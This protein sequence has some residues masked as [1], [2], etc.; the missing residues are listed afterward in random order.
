VAGQPATM[1][2]TR[3]ADALRQLSVSPADPD[4]RRLVEEARFSFE[5]DHGRVSLTGADLRANLRQLHES[6]IPAHLLDYDGPVVPDRVGVNPRFTYMLVFILVM[7]VL[8]FGCNNA[9][10]EIVKEEAIFARERA[11]NLGILPYIASKFVVLVAVTTLHAFLLTALVL[12]VL[13]LLPLVFAGHT[14][15]HPDHVLAFIPLLGVFVLLAMTGVALGL[16]LSACVSTPD[17]ANALLPYVLIPQMILGGGFL[18]VNHG[19][20]YWLAGG[21][22]PVY[23]AYRAAHV[24]AAGLPAGFPGSVEYEEG[25]LLPCEALVLQSAVL[26]LCAAWFLRRKGG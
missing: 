12:G 18:A 10:K 13:Y 17:R 6:Q 5:T 15:P 23:W 2:A 3:V 14:A 21:L 8:W 20:M 9:A 16:L 22:S 1:D 24:G 4:A 26:L 19:L 11:V 25:A 7:V